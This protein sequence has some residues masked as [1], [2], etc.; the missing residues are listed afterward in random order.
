MIRF[1]VSNFVSFS[2]PCCSSFL[3]S[4]CFLDLNSTQFLGNPAW[5]SPWSISMFLLLS[6]H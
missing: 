3:F 5:L 6:L 4:F 1:Q 2:R